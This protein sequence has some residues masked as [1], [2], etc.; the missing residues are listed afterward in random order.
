MLSER[1]KEYLGSL[2][3]AHLA[4]LSK[5]HRVA[6]EYIADY[7][8]ELW[9][10]TRALEVA[11]LDSSPTK[12]GEEEIEYLIEEYAAHCRVK[13]QKWY[14]SIFS[15]YLQT[16]KNHVV[17]E[18]HLGWP[19][20]NRVNVDWLSWEE[21]AALIDAADGPEI[22]L[23][24]L[25]LRLLLRR[26]EVQRLTM[27]DIHIGI[28]DVR[29]K[30]RYGGKWRTLSWAPET[31]GVLQDWMER[32]EE[33]I[34]EARSRSPQLKVPDEFLIYRRGKRL[35][36]YSDSGL[37]KLLHQAARRAGIQR[38]FGHH[39][40]RRSGA[41]FVIQVDADNMP[42]LVEVLGHESESQTRRYCALTIDDMTEMHTQVSSHLEVT[43]ER[44][45]RTGESPKP[46][47]VRIVR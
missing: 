41:R 47:A 23:I 29:G 34:E 37:D 12:V 2:I 38:Q 31:L 3:E 32:R 30:G 40:L 19:K 10:M 22:P 33:M 43:K 5:R 18:M 14:L 9:R 17:A 16:H 27:E 44:M 7:R 35:E 15:G 1:R 4:R 36:G 6:E 42:V 46:P 13:T 24:H 28:L 26:C 20:D 21:A 11:G 25:E 45:R 8:R 39:T